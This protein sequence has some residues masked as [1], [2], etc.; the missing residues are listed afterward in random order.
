MWIALLE[1]LSLLI[2]DEKLK[3]LPGTLS[4]INGQIFCP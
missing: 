3:G 1:I 4:V 2:P